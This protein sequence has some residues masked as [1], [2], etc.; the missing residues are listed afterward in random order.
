[1]VGSPSP[2]LEEICRHVSLRLIDLGKPAE[3]SDFYTKHPY[4]SPDMIP[5]NAY[6]CVDEGVESFR[7][8]AVWV[9]SKKVDDEVVFEALTH[10]FSA[11]GLVQMKKAH[12]VARGLKSEEAGRDI[13]IPFHP[14]AKRYWE[15]RK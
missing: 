8:Q 15:S 2:S 13:A 9:A 6:S 5:A 7:D 4:Y 10:L 1:M 14:G 11:E 3:D 12:P